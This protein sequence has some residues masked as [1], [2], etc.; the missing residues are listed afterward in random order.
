MLARVA[1]VLT[2][3]CKIVGTASDGRGALDAARA[4]GPDVI[5]LDISMP[6]M[7][8]F[9]VASRLR[10]SGSKAAVVFLTV[11]DEEGFVQA[12]IAAG[13]IG[14]VVKSRL[15]SDLATAV[16]EARAGRPFVSP[17]R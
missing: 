16:R 5:V 8:G 14:Y 2:P 1:S 9:E 17:I 7:T 13:G 11:H 12:A 6:G 3:G 15:A 10:T 4:L